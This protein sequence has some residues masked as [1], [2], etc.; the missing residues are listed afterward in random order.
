M[1]E[2]KKKHENAFH[3]LS[4]GETQ[5]GEVC[6]RRRNERKK[7]GRRHKTQHAKKKRTCARSFSTGEENMM[8]QKERY[9]LRIGHAT[10]FCYASTE[11]LLLLLK[12]ADDRRR[13][14]AKV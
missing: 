12:H 3:T 13:E 7:K 2:Q 5:R 8:G 9:V 1:L 4:I 6:Y 10:H 14:P 11:P